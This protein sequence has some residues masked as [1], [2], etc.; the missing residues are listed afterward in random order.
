MEELVSVFKNFKAANG[1]ISVLGNHDY[2]SPSPAFIKE[3]LNE[4]NIEILENNSI[5]IFPNGRILKLQDLRI[6]GIFRISSQKKPLVPFIHQ[7]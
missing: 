5:H 6:Y 3:F 2:A 1:V 4:A 7:Q